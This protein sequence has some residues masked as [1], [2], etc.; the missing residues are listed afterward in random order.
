MLDDEG[1][2]SN[3]KGVLPEGIYCSL[4]MSIEFKESNEPLI[5]KHKD[6]INKYES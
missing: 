3:K 6:L 4:I 2:P 1:T 5:K